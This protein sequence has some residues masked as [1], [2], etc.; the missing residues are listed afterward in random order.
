MK[1]D[2][3]SSK[4]ELKSAIQATQKD[5]NASKTELKSA[6]E[7]TQRDLNASK[8]E[9]KSAIQATQKDLRES[10][11]E[12]KAAI[13]A[14]QNDLRETKKDL[15]TQI[16]VLDFKTEGLRNDFSDLRAETGLKLDTIIIAIDGISRKITDGQT[17]LHA[18]NS[19][20]YRHEDMLENHEARIGVL[21]SGGKESK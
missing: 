16:H 18:M 1:N 3:N 2:L 8:T 14:T 7:A 21:E 19:A 6:I 12:L 13:Q 5:L 10:K 11:T 4:V 20:L 17:E 9:L 15:Q